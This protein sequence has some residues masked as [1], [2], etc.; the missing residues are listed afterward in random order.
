MEEVKTA[1]DQN[2]EN[3]LDLVSDEYLRKKKRNKKIIFSC[4]SAF[5]LA[6]AIVIITLAC[7]RVDLK[8]FFLNEPTSIDIHTTEGTYSLAPNDENYS[9]YN[10]IFESSFNSTVL[11][12]MFTGNLGAYTINEERSEYF[13]SDS[14]NKTG[15]NSDLSEYLTDNYI[16]LYY[17]QP[18]SLK[19][20]DGSQYYSRFSSRTGAMYFKDVYF[21][22][23]DTDNE[24][25]LT[26]Y[27]GG[28]TTREGYSDNRAQI[29]K[30]SVRANTYRLYQLAIGEL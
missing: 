19:N 2:V 20:A 14:D 9:K 4:I 6:L 21:N 25:E 30:I 5:V 15:I 18:Q 3:V 26:F 17:S 16:H 11:T 7:V 24:E 23:T 8:P 1:Q 12:A 28:Y 13:Y 29:V 27:I 10:D 22:I